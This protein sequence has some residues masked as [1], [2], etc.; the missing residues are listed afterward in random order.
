MAKDCRWQN[1]DAT[2]GC[3][4]PRMLHFHHK[5]GGGT[6][7]RKGGADSKRM[8][9]YEI[10]RATEAR[11]EPRFGLLCANCHEIETKPQR[12]GAI[13]HHGPA[14]IRKSQ[15]KPGQPERRVRTR[16]EIEAERGLP[17]K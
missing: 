15:Q 14:K 6:A 2:Q 4:D 17:K 13:L 3:N 5:H 12:Q 10:L 9:S 11:V 16:D 1:E 8:I 7:A